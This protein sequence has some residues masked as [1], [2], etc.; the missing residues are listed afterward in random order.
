MG[1][2]LKWGL[3]EWG[4]VIEWETVIEW[5]TVIEWETFIEWW[6][7]IEVKCASIVCDVCDKYEVV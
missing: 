3:V 5:G 7:I 2:Q 4:T 1:D 6:A